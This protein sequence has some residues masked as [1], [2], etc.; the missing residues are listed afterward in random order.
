MLKLPLITP[1]AI[2]DLLEIWCFI[3]EDN[4][5]AADSVLEVIQ[6]KC[7]V[8]A[9]TPGVGRSREDLAPNLRSVVTSS[10]VIFYR[11]NETGAEIVRVMHGARDFDAIFNVG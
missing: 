4:M 2:A 7:N 10:Y 8:I 9:N 5:P 1:A 6:E 11:P 3:A